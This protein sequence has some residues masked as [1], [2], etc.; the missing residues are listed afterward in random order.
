MQTKLLA[1]K[2]FVWVLRNASQ[3][4]T[5]V[6]SSLIL[7]LR[8]PFSKQALKMSILKTMPLPT[9]LKMI[10]PLEIT[11][12]EGRLKYLCN[13]RFFFFFRSIVLDHLNLSKYIS[14]VFNTL[15][16]AFKQLVCRIYKGF[17]TVVVYAFSNLM[18]E[19]MFISITLFLNMLLYGC[20]FLCLHHPRRNG[21]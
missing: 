18:N 20:V 6:P 7:V 2:I 5:S 1:L 13:K 12:S 10:P 15:G 11:L 16:R 9:L 17:W 3:K 19:W 4:L 21:L 8:A 14:L